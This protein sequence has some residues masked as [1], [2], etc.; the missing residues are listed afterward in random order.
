MLS[1]GELGNRRQRFVAGSNAS[2]IPCPQTSISLPVHTELRP[3]K[4]VDAGGAGRR[5]HVFEPG[6]YEA[7]ASRRD[8]TAPSVAR[9]VTRPKTSIR[10][11]VHTLV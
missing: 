11:P 1:N 6:S 10:L 2:R 3:M 9:L 4:D 8:R 7:A 5:R